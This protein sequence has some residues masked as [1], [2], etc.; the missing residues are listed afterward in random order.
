MAGEPFLFPLE[1]N[2]NR[3]APVAGPGAYQ[4]FT[5]RAYWRRAT[6]A[7]VNCTHHTEGWTTVLP[8]T[9]QGREQAD[10][11]RYHS[12]R[13]FI[14][15]TT[16]QGWVQFSFPPGQTCFS[17]AEHKIA[18]EEEPVGLLI[19]GDHRATTGPAHRYDRLDQMVDDFKSHTD[20]IAAARDRAGA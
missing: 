5:A 10:Y 4:T 1:S 16:D 14:E 6:C 15:T 18:A 20:Q 7:E 9:P 11:I 2:N 19:P 3:P 17:A 8:P 13:R 12:G